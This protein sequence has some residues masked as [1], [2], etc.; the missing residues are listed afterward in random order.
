M[1]FLP[2]GDLLVSDISGKIYTERIKSLDLIRSQIEKTTINKIKEKR[3]HKKSTKLFLRIPYGTNPA[4][5]SH[6][7][8]AR[9]SKT[10]RNLRKTKKT[11]ENQ[12]K[13][14]KT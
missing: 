14:R 4:I 2:N 7:K 13:T 1:S 6:H 3:I 12:R 10:K 5:R 11:K 8:V 9:S